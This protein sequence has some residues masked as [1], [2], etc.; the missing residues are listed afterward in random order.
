MLAGKIPTGM[1]REFFYHEDTK[2]TKRRNPKSVLARQ[3]FA[4]SESSFYFFLIPPLRVLCVFVVVPDFSMSREQSAF[5]RGL[6]APSCGAHSASSA[7]N[8]PAKC[9]ESV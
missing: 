9:S 7:V 6:S 4:L 2:D 1:R 5:I 8:F 3:P